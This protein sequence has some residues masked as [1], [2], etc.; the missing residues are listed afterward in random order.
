MPKNKDA[1]SK[2]KFI[3]PIAI[4]AIIFLGVGIASG[5]FRNN[6][7]TVMKVPDFEL[8]DQNNKKIT[9]KDMLGKVYLVE[10]FY[11][12]C[13]TICPVMNSNM[14]AIEDAVNS[15]DFGIISISID[16]DNDTPEILKQHA[17]SVGSKSPNW[18]FLTG[19]RTYIGNLADQFN[20]YVGDEEDE[21]ESLNHSGM[22]A[23]V[24]KEGNVRCRYNKDNMPILYY[25]GLNYEDPEGK[26][27]QLTGKYH[28]DRE[29]L[30]EDIKKL[31]Q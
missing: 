12:R 13:P 2:A 31:L 11:S 15:P 20:I 16:P 5:Y 26:T 3:I 21:G 6:L 25:S 9:N 10:F 4:I 29:I 19:D 22:I 27:P 30:I 1:G 23:L 17:K 8:T 14:R 18:H 28:P 24:D 7:Y